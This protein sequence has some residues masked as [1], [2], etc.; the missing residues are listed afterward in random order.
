ML[1]ECPVVALDRNAESFASLEKVRDAVEQRGDVL[2]L[3]MQQLRDAYGVRRL[4]I[5]VSSA[6]HAELTQ[7]GLAHSPKELP[8]SQWEPVLV[9]RA[10]SHVARVISAVLEPGEAGD[11][12]LRR[13][14]D[15]LTAA[16]DGD[17]ARARKILDQI[18]DLVFEESH[19]NGVG[20]P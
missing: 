12:I 2:T 5:H 16:G 8:L 4:G 11:E 20:Q 17:G 15:H 1:E 19:D 9:Y 6:I 14:V 3:T 18:R 13:A 7:L 10:N